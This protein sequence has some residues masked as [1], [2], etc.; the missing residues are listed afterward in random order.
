[1]AF[2]RNN[3]HALQYCLARASFF[4]SKWSVHG[5]S[6]GKRTTSFPWSGAL[7]YFELS[8]MGKI[9]DTRFP[10][11]SL[12]WEKLVAGS[13]MLPAISRAAGSLKDTNSRYSF[14]SW[15]PKSWVSL[16]SASAYLFFRSPTGT[17]RTSHTKSFATTSP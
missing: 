13:R 16:D 5:C 17:G 10:T 11:S 12:I 1:M 15:P 9:Q 2:L 8:L 3:P 14:D 7:L 4:T 6:S